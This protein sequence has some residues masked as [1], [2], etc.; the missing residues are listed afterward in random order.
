MSKEVSWS[1]RIERLRLIEKL[2]LEQHPNLRTSEI[3]EKFGVS[4]DTVLR[5]LNL[6]SSTGMLP[7]VKDGQYWKL[8]K[9][10]VNKSFDAKSI[11]VEDL[12]HYDY[13]VALS[14]AS[15]DRS[16]ADVLATLLQREGVKVFYDKYEKATLWGQDL[17]IYLSNIYQ[18]KA[19][20]CVMFLSQHYAAKLWTSHERQAAQA[21]AFKE[22]SAYILPIRLD[23]TLI[24]GI[25]PTTAYLT[26]HQETVEDVALAILE[27]L[28]DFSPKSLQQWRDECEDYLKAGHKDKALIACKKA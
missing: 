2:F 18:N 9:A 14:Y 25:L 12:K 22:Q 4:V 13:D 10:V 20:Y 23:D 3:A 24:P 27:K 19:R 17:Y 11:P 8:V 15:E 28:V 5:D 7:L 26:W 1:N 21:R 16:Y 6:L